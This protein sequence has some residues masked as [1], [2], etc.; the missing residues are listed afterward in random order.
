MNAWIRC[1]RW[2]ADPFRPRT[3]DAPAERPPEQAVLEA[4]LGYTFRD[5]GLCREALTHVSC[6][7]TQPDI[8]TLERLEFLGDAILGAV[9]AEQL[10]RQFPEAPEGKLTRLRS[11]LV[12]GKHLSQ[13][14][15]K[16]EL[17]DHV[18]M[19]ASERRAGGGNRAGILEDALEALIG[20]I[21]L[22]S[23]YPTARKVVLAWLGDLEPHATEMAP[24]T[25]PKGR[26]QERLQAEHGNVVPVY[27]IVE[28][29][30]PA[31]RRSFRAVVGFQENTLGEGQG[32]S[33]KAAE[34]AA[35]EA[36]LAKIQLASAEG[37][38]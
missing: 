3:G 37:G 17:A 31:H 21:F 36:A 18:R 28:V 35:A 22:D 16:L 6:K 5:L 13:L 15:R 34:E 29:S 8:P 38:D 26:L 7:A 32:S 20:A 19:S 30:G 12:S 23:D 14:A 33:K 4:S 10:Y 11:S 2:L 1:W 24:R 25:N 27:T 9:L